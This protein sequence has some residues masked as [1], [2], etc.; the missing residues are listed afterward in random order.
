MVNLEEL[1][2][3]EDVMDGEVENDEGDRGEDDDIEVLGV[4]PKD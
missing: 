1:L 4:W 3:E 2:R